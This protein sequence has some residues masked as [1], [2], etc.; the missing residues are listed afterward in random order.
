VRLL[1]NKET[2]ELANVKSARDHTLDAM[3]LYAREMESAIEESRPFLKRPFEGFNPDAANYAT[4]GC[5]SSAYTTSYST[6]ISHESEILSRIRDIHYEVCTTLPKRLA[7]ERLI[8][9]LESDVC[10][11]DDCRKCK[12]YV[13]GSVDG[14]DKSR[15]MAEYLLDH[16]IV[17]VVKTE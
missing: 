8:K 15:A 11:T 17:R 6:H 1:K 14:C 7:L 12:Y 16:N 13:A 2:S 5:V 9:A 3:E 10:P 4:S